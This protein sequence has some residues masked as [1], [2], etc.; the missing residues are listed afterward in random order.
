LSFAAADGRLNRRLIPQG[1]LHG[2]RRLG[3]G[4]VKKRIQ[5]PARCSQRHRSVAGGEQ[6]SPWELVE[7]SAFQERRSGLKN[8][9][10][11]GHEDILHDKVMGPGPAHTTHVP[12]VQQRGFGSGHKQVALLGLTV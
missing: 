6:Q 7:R 8:R 3:A 12:R 10:L 1:G 2:A 11:G 4:K 5:A 9:S